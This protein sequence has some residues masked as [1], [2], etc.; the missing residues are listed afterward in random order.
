MVLL[1]FAEAQVSTTGDVRGS[2]L[3]PSGAAIA[4]VAVKLIDEATGVERG[5][6]TGQ[7]GGF[8][9]PR[10]QPGIYRITAS[11][12]G[13]E[14]SIS[15]GV[16]VET[17]RTTDVAM[18][19]SLGAVTQQVE[20]E[21]VATALETT[22]NAI[23]STVRNESIQELPV[24]GRNLLGFSLLT[25]GAQRGSTDR[26]SDF[27]GLPNA[28]LNITLD[29]ISNNDWRFKSGGTSMFVFAPL[30]LGAMEQVNV[31]TAG[32]GADASGSG[33]M[34]IRWVTKRGTNHFHGSAFEEFLNTDLNADTW[35]NNANGLAR[36]VLHH[37]E[38]GGNF[39]GPLWKN[40]LFFFINYEHLLQPAQTAVVNAVLNPAAQ[41]GIFTYI[42]TDNLT[43][44]ANLLQIAAAAGFPGTVDPTIASQLQRMNAALA[45]GIVTTQDLIRNNLN[46]NRRGGTND[47][48]EKYPTARVDYQIAPKLG[49]DGAWNLRWRDIN[50]SPTWPG[51]HPQSE[52]IST[53]FIVSMGLNWTISPSIFNEFRF[54]VQGGPEMYNAGESL[55]QFLVNGRMQQI[56]YPLGIP[57]LTRNTLPSPDNNPVYNINDNLNWIKGRHTFTF[58][59]SWIRASLWDADLGGGNEGGVPP[60]VPQLTLGVVAS[61]A[62]A[63]V[64]TASTLPAIRSNDLPNALA[65][66]ALLTGRLSGITNSE[67]VNE[68]TKQYQPLVPFVRREALTT[69]GVYFQDTFRVNSSLTLNYGLR[70]EFTGDNYDTNGIYTSPT[71]ADLL[72]PSSAPFQ[73]GVFTGV[74]NPQIYQRS[75]TYNGSYFNP[76]PNLGLA[77][78]PHAEGR[79]GRILGKEKTVI[80][81]GIGVTYYQEGTQ[82]FEDYTSNNPGFIQTAFLTPGLTGF[83]PGS[84]S[85]SGVIPDLVT[86]PASFSPPFPQSLFTF[87]GN[88]LSTT[89]QHLHQPYVT[90]WSVGIQRELFRGAVLE[91]R[92]VGNKGTHVWHGYNLNETNIFEN[93]FLK[94][95]VNAQNNLAIN[96]A[97]G[98]ASIANRGLPGQV[99]LPMFESAF[100]A[101][102]SQPA[103]AASAGFANGTFITDLQQG[104]AGLLAHSLAGSSTYLCR[105]A[106]S[107]LSPCS[108]L[109]F[110]V[111]GLYPINVF[112]PNPYFAGATLNLMA[113]NSNT[114]YNGLQ[115]EF[116][117]KL[118]SLT[119]SVNYTY[120]KSLTDLFVESADA[121]IN[122]TT[123]RNKRLNKGPNT[124][125]T[126]HAFVGYF[127]YLLPFG[128][129]HTMSD[130]A[131]VNR[132][133]GGW[134]L[135][136]VF[137]LQSGL[138]IRLTSGRETVNQNDSGVVLNG[139]TRDQLQSMFTI[140]PGPNKNISFVSPLLVGSDGRA[141]PTYILTPTTPG[142]FGD[143][144][145]LNGP[146]QITTDMSVHKVIPVREAIRMELAV[147]ALNAFN[148]PLF[149]IGNCTSFVTVCSSAQGVN[150]NINSTTFGQTSALGISPRSLQL[151]LEVKF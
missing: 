130:N 72:G 17:A 10:V 105:M 91:V 113:D 78:N 8:V 87:S 123:L 39:G 68:N 6:V 35:F 86:V 111:P 114:T 94:D 47:I 82:T 147:D 124:F 79:L 37:N 69:S 27:N 92:Y 80:R 20:V 40:K 122:Y 121:I 57:L 63:S 148:H 50:G 43:H 97:S 146:K 18:K 107:L 100:G 2:V 150:V 99:A 137:R 102:G 76:A 33:A 64:L 81:G 108:G 51:F 14:T 28:S 42:G 136:T 32:I 138:P 38:F 144:V 149:L 58:G 11:A 34:Q 31:S 101:L 118:G 116:R 109:G 52:F 142:Q 115:M 112:Q 15:S 128:K 25:A 143:N 98:V 5:T 65:L 103:L 48:R 55:S 66:Y 67:A 120:S 106:G 46:F 117:R 53:Y 21:G 145:F 19:L 13:F 16:T 140:R 75:H 23:S 7:D 36:P 88:N 85:V 29:G 77:W 30:R 60:G 12:K 24:S 73:P 151:R 89:L 83:A 90:N 134:A 71:V 4:D 74:Q 44:T 26:D 54:G 3:D 62:V 61:D 139:I 95:F 93:G 119:Y 131:V 56:N 141:N 9:F 1:P 84:L 129:G 45:S 96:Q 59:G 135:S 22:S 132:L 133:I 125:D 49:F 126:R 104:Q 110:G 41:Q 70:F 127:N